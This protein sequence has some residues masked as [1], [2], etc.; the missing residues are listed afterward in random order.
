MDDVWPKWDDDLKRWVPEN[1]HYSEPSSFLDTEQPASIV[2]SVTPNWSKWK[3]MRA[4]SIRSAVSLALNLNPDVLDQF[5]LDSA[6]QKYV[7]LLDVSKGLHFLR[8]NNVGYQ[9]IDL[10]DYGVYLKR[11]LKSMLIEGELPSEFPTGTSTSSEGDYSD[12]DISKQPSSPKDLDEGGAQKYMTTKIRA[13]SVIM[14]K[15]EENH[16]KSAIDTVMEMTGLKRR[17]ATVI[18]SIIN[19]RPYQGSSKWPAED[20]L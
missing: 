4:V 7:D 8:L 9:M 15:I 2:G 1:I 17:E 20:E 6:P 3:F 14:R 10:I 12:Q 13:L 18:L 19:K 5:A 11:N 16:T